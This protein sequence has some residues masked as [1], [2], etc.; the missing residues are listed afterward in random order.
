MRTLGSAAGDVERAAGHLQLGVG[1]RELLPRVR[2]AGGDVRGVRSEEK[3]REIG[4]RDQQ[5]FSVRERDDCRQDHRLGG[6]TKMA[7]RK[8]YL[9]S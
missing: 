9:P 2:L 3:E 1:L 7:T 4:E 5:R 8:G 6:H